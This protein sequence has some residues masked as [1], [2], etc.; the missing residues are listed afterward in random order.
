MY[1]VKQ[2]SDL[3]SVS[4]RTLHYYDAIG[5][6]HPAQI[7]ENGYRYY[8]EAA[9]LRLQQILFYRELG[10]ELK[11]IK[12]I[13]DSPDFDLATALE[14]H[15][16]AL[17]EKM[18]RLQNLISTVDETIMHVTGG[19]DMS[20]KKKLF[21]AFSD[22]QQKQYEREARLQYG[23]ENVNESIRR[24]NSYSNVQREIIMDEGNEIYTDLVALMEDGTPTESAEVQ[25][26]MARW[27]QHLRYFYEPTLEVLSGL[28][29]TYNSQPE[30]V[31]NF[32]KIHP[33]LPEYLSASVAQ[34]VDELEY[35]EIARLLA[36]DE[37]RADQA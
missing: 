21:Q 2:I 34:Y 10:L 14:S 31:A 37:T 9:L 13:L 15:R 6:L 8:D 3:A 7:G 28:G 33:D 24:W 22:E 18:H 26:V 17:K 23:P 25:A 36:E 16:E 27:H 19:T 11:Q 35:A 20:N 5:L 1:T 12:D 29:M 30:F 4:V 32:K